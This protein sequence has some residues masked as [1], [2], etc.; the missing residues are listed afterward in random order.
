MKNISR[1][2]RYF[3]LIILFTV[4]SL[5][6]MTR[7]VPAAGIGEEQDGIWQDEIDREKIIEGQMKSAGIGELEDHLE[8]YSG[9]GLEELLPGYAPGDIINDAARGNLTLNAGGILSKILNLLF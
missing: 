4:I 6:V 2:K 9:E 7:A 5:V 3:K 1:H 8:R